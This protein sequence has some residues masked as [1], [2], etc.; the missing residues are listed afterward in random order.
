M[1]SVRLLLASALLGLLPAAPVHA[2]VLL[3]PFV[4]GNFSGSTDTL[5]TN[6]TGE[7]SRTTFGGSLAT[8]AG[9]IFGIEADVGYTP[10]FFGTDVEIGGVPVG[11]VSNNVLTATLNL[12]AGIPLQ[13]RGGPGLRP[14]AVAG[15]GLIRQEFDLVG[16]LAEYRA[17]DVGYDIGGG[18]LVFVSRN[19]GLRGEVRHFRTLGGDAV[20]DLLDFEPGAFNFTRATV[21]L[22]LR[23]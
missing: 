13:S 9:G 5:L 10:R 15:V 3:T 4:G 22:T 23:Y 11:I 7:P 6:L 17:N 2:D 14:Y 21:G 16:G 12:T 18:L 8:M 20:S 19:V 1:P